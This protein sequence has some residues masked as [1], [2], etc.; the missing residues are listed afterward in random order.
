MNIKYDEKD[1][2]KSP[3]NYTGGKYKLLPKLFR[4]FP[5][6]SDI[7]LDLF[8]GGFNVGINANANHIIYN[9]ILEP[10]VDL[11]KYLQQEPYITDILDYIDNTIEEFDLRKDNKKG[12]LAF[13]DRYNSAD[14]KNPLDLYILSAFSFSNQIRFNKSGGFNMPFGKRFFN[15]NMRKNLINFVDTLHKKDVVFLSED[16]RDLNLNMSMGLTE[17][18][19]VYCDPPYLISTASYNE[20]GGWTD[21]DERALLRKLSELDSNGVKF[22]LSNVLH[23]KGQGNIILLDWL[24][25]N[26]FTVYNVESNYFNC[27][28]QKKDRESLTLE[29]LIVNY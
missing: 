29:V 12:Y 21:D 26:G 19:F 24:Q 9:D 7:F 5:E 3:M 15:S 28:Y 13:R 25:S 22:A 27:N 20:N 2:I 6:T 10:M 4:V 23:H 16:F 11:F 17:D 1:F 14:Y 18:S 8:G